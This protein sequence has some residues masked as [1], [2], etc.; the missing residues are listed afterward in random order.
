M[1][2]TGGRYLNRIITCPPGEIRPAQDRMRESMFAILG[3]ISGVSFLDLFA[4]SGVIAMEA[5]SRGAVKAH[6]V[7]KDSGK[8]RTILKN[9]EIIKI[10]PSSPDVKLLIRPVERYLKSSIARFDIVHC[11]PPFMMR[12]K[13]GILQLAEK[14]AQPACG[15]TLM[16]HYPREEMLPDSPGKLKC[17]DERRYGRSMLRFYTRD[18]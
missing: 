14:A 9:L 1:R 10:D 6:L 15:G 5:L 13:A 7:E 3:N 12:N 18:D 4:G 11:D 17:Y 16:I 8:K 2:I